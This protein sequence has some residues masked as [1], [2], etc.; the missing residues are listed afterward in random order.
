VL[1]VTAGL[2]AAG[3]SRG[4]ETARAV[5]ERAIKAHG[6]EEKLTKLRADKVKLK[7]VLVFGAREAP[8]T[9]ET[10]VQLPGQFKNVMQITVDGRAFTLLQI[11]PRRRSASRRRDARTCECTS[12]RNQPC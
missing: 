9:A 12:T 2:L 11:L 10:T 1:V 7:G 6:G 3:P 4:Q 5:I 8:F